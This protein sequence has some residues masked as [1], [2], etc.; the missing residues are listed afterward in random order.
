MK[1]EN[2]KVVTFLSGKGGS[3]KT[4]I[5]IAIAKLLADMGYPCI[6]IDLD[7][8]TNGASY[9]FRRYFKPR[10][11]GVWER[12]IE[13]NSDIAP[14]KISKNFF[15]LPSRVKLSKRGMHYEAMDF[16]RVRL[17]NDVLSPI[18]MWAKQANCKYILID[19]QAGY[20]VSSEAATRVADTTVIVSEADSISNDAAE[21]LRAQLIDFLPEENFYLINKI[22]IRDADTYRSFKN[23]LPTFN[24]LPPLPFDFEV[25]NAFGARQIPVDLKEPSSML[26]AIFETL[27]YLFSE[28]YDIIKEYKVKHLNSIFEEYDEELNK[29]V[30]ERAHLE[31]QKYKLKREQVRSKYSSNIFFVP[32]ISIFTASIVFFTFNSVFALFYIP[33]MFYYF[34][35]P[36]L[37]ISGI[38]LSIYW[39]YWKWRINRRN[40]F[41]EA[42][43]EEL[44]LRLDSINRKIDNFRSLLW[45]KSK[46]FLMDTEIVERLKHKKYK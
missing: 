15:F 10:N 31:A 24:R 36:G 25:R 19:C 46:D 33:R 32:V 45:T 41:L 30:S 4:T 13:G 39:V 21:N 38:G 40:Q 28:I 42:E 14:I 43:E 29:L 22:D 35:F 23:L 2:F 34:I 9:F 37:L 6:L 20:T 18:F 12:I 5:S 7:L 27:K 8:A 44:T 11:I 3:G 17:M 16:S 1:G 26:F